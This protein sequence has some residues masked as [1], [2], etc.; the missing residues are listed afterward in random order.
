MSCKRAFEKWNLISNNLNRDRLDRYLFKRIGKN[1][2]AMLWR[3]N[4]SMKQ[5]G[6][7]L[8]KHSA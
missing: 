3:P 6:I 1:T 4:H 8:L 2:G 7:D 5:F